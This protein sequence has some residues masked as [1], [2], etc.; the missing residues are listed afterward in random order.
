M[1]IFG[2][3]CQFQHA[4]YVIVTYNGNLSGS[5]YHIDYYL[6]KFSHNSFRYLHF[7]WNLYN[8]D[9]NKC[10]TSLITAIS[11]LLVQLYL[12]IIIVQY[13]TYVRPYL[14]YWA[15]LLLKISYRII[16]ICMESHFC[17]YSISRYLIKGHKISY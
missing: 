6:L 12:L 7:Q 3:I 5:L 9:I 16:C 13:F 11:F 15:K 10:A 4:F 14:F 1:T 17:I 8:S 2:Q